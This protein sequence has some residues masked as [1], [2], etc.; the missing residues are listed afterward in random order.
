MS[1]MRKVSKDRYYIYRDLQAE[2]GIG[3]IFHTVGIVVEIINEEPCGSGKDILV[4]HLDPQDLAIITSWRTYSEIELY[5]I[6]KEEH[7]RQVKFYDKLE[8]LDI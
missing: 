2:Y 1:T 6:H 4:T 7:N 5:E 8:T 3:I